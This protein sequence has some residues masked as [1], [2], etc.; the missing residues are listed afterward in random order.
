MLRDWCNK[1]TEEDRK[2]FMIEFCKKKME[3]AVKLDLI[4]TFEF[5]LFI[6]AASNVNFPAPGL[7]ILSSTNPNSY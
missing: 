5:L 6:S 4:G 2:F 1:L 7:H 3:V